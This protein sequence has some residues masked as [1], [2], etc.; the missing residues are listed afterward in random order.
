[1]FPEGLLYSKEKRGVLTPR[2]N[3]LFALIT[4]SARVLEENKK[5]YSV[6]S[7]LNS[8]LVVL[9]I[10]LSNQ[11]VEDFIAFVNN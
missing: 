11:F 8:C 5:D 1:M 7:S 9:E 4:S 10:K 3:S 2:V 6:K